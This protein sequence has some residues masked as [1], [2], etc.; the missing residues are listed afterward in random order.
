[1]FLYIDKLH[2]EEAARKLRESMAN[3]G[4]SATAKSEAAT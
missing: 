2:K 3:S 1:M 4:G